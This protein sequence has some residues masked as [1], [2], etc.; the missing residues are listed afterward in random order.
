MNQVNAA[1]MMRSMRQTI[2]AQ[3]NGAQ[4]VNSFNS[5][6]T[7]PSTVRGELSPIMERM[8]LLIDEIS[9]AHANMHELEAKLAPVRAAV[10]LSDDEEAMGLIPEPSEV[11]DRLK[12]AYNHVRGLNARIAALRSELRI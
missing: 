7:K 11:E 1:D 8:S 12:M 5:D 9:H 6:G 2:A 10:P 4:S 3:S